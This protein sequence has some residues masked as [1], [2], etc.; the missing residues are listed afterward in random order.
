M[1]DVALAARDVGHALLFV[2]FDDWLGEIE[3]DGAVFVS[4]GV[5]EKGEILH[6]AEAGSKRG[7]TLGHFRIAFENFVDVRVGHAFGGAN[8]A[9]SHARGFHVAGAVGEVNGGAAETRFTVERRG[10]SNVMRDIGDVHL[11]VPSAVGAM[12]DVNGVVEIARG[13]SIDCDDRQVAEIFAAPTLHFAY[14]LR[15]SLGFVQDLGR[16]DVREMVLANDDFGV[17]AEIAGAA[18]NFDD[19]TGGRCAAAREAEQLDVDDGTVEFIQ[20]WDAP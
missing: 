4:A 5:E 6:V 9:G 12:L 17:D 1:S 10:G 19:A 14:R 3:V 7:V 8:E 20:A 13:L 2:K 15:A 18:E 11:Q 16:E